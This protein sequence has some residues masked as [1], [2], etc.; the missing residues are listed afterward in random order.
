MIV[1]VEGLA[2]G[3]LFL[4]GTGLVALSVGALGLV[5]GG[6]FGLTLLLLILRADTSETATALSGMAQ[7]VGYLVAATGPP[8]FGWLYDQTG[9]WTV[10]LASL[11]VVL[12]LKLVV[13]LP[14]ARDEVCR[15]E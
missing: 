6:S 12:A 3:G 13:G 1:V 4:P 15:T 11:L 2:L 10:P 5:L 14:A 7:S 9:D 8:L